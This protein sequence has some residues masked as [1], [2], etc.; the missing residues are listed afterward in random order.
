MTRDEFDMLTLEQD[1]EAEGAGIK[2]VFKKFFKRQEDES[3]DSG[4]KEP[5][6]ESDESSEDELLL[7]RLE[8]KFDSLFQKSNV[9]LN[10]IIKK[11]EKL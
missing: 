11:I 2:K 5:S 7:E 9:D 1:R 4:S 3:T 10:R 8:N 6:S